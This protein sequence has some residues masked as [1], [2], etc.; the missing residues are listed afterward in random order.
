[1]DVPFSELFSRQTDLGKKLLEAQGLQTESLFPGEHF[2]WPMRGLET[3][4]GKD[5]Y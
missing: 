2:N 3:T 5:R 4:A 1:M